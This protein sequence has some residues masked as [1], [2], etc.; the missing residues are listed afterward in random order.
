MLALVS[1]MV[2]VK[3]ILRTP[4]PCSLIPDSGFVALLPMSVQIHLR[5]ELQ[6]MELLVIAHMTF[7][8]GLKIFW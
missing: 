5:Q 3:R 7:R 2:R 8:N 4:G 6:E 1:E